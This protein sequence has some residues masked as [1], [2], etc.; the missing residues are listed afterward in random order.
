MRT[1]VSVYLPAHFS[2]PQTADVAAFVAAAAS[3]DLVTFDGTKPVASLIPVIWDQETGEHGRLLGH[4]ALA[5]GFGSLDHVKDALHRV[6]VRNPHF[7]ILGVGAELPQLRHELGFK[8]CDQLLVVQNLH[9]STPIIDAGLHSRDLHIS[10][11][12]AR[13][14]LCMQDRLLGTLRQ[15]A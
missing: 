1:L 7:Q 13:I 4:L 6:C 12:H 15:A 9:A 14:N 5:K 2:A 8:I 11:L 10:F 3:A